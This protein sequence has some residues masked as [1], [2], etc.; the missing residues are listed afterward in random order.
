MK[1]TL[2]A[3]TSIILLLTACSQ[4]APSPTP[5]PP[6]TSTPLPP[7]A[8]VLAP[9]ATAAPSPTSPL[10]PPTPSAALQ[11][12]PDQA[13]QSVFDDFLEQ[14]FSAQLRRDP[15]LI[16]ELGLAAA[17]GMDNSQLT[18]VSDA[19][20]QETYALLQTQLETLHSFDRAALTPDRQLSYD[21]FA[22]GLDDRLRGQ[23]FRFHTYPVNQLFGVQNVFVEFMT[24]RHPLADLQDARDY[25]ARLEA[26]ATKID[27]TL[28][29]LQIQEAQGILPPQFLVQRVL[30][31]LRWYA[32]QPAAGTALYSAF[33]SKLSALE[34]VNPGQRATLS[35]DAA[36]AIDVSVLPAYQRLLEY[37]QHLEGIA[38]TD[39]G[40]WQH[41]DGAAAYDYWLRHHTTTT[42]TADQIHDIGLQEVARL[43]AEMEALFSELGITGDSLA[44]KMDQVAA[45][46]GFVEPEAL[47]DA[48]QALIDDADQRL[49][50]L[51]DVRPEIGVVVVTV[52]QP[53]GA[54]AY[55]VSPA[56][57]GSR[58]GT[59]YVNLAAGVFPRYGMPT[60]TYHEAI[61]GHHFQIAIQQQ[62]TGVPSFR[63]GTNYT[64]YVEGWALYAEQLAWEAGFY[65]DDPYGNLG[66]L[67][68][69]LFRAARLV[70]DT[71]IHA[72]HW[73][74]EQAIA[75]MVENVGYPESQ[76]TAEVERYIAWPGQATSYKIGMRQL[77][78]LRQR[79]MDALGDR[80]D[81][82]AFHN[83]ILTNGAMPLQILE[84]VVD[85][86]IAATLR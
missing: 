17:F 48:Y 82:K 21:L 79:A 66:R 20:Q 80:F 37:F 86:Y 76:M 29:W 30:G 18:D 69:E 62:L 77:L 23:E 43:Q 83:L 72:Q 49:A 19:F 31:Q 34:N 8:P 33:T 32:S 36:H 71:G 35:Q 15:E 16:S 63:K 13:L 57:D 74:R 64:A 56:I 3:L 11:P 42:L 81:I 84:R 2:L 40:F 38:P 26:F 58:P 52:E 60:L 53:S 75:Y 44:A 41:P 10:Q 73:T 12:T 1:K 54:G 85:D 39:D 14:A 47:A 78:E 50:D 68:S 6:H 61:P 25:V 7:T 65:A 5:S 27:Q 59:F 24:D 70:V 51:F 67:Q 45:R 55:Y 28:E 4:P 9:T 46:G 22:W